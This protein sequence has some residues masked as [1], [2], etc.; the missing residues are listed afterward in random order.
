VTR[1]FTFQVI[2]PGTDSWTAI[3]EMGFASKEFMPVIHSMRQH[4]R[5]APPEIHTAQFQLH[6]FW[7]QT[8]CDY[9]F[10]RRIDGTWSWRMITG[11][12]RHGEEVLT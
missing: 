10:E 6:G 1:D 4:L 8:I 11:I 2:D 3:M 9:Q 5:T 7:K 12:A